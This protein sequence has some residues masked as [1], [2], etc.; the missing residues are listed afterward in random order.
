MRFYVFMQPAK[1]LDVMLS[2]IILRN[3]MLSRVDV[4]ADNNKL[5]SHLSNACFFFRILCF[6]GTFA[7]K[8]NVV[9]LKYK[10]L[11]PKLAIPA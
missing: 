9:P 3:K 1:L 10:L 7:P 4:S 5:T 2:K 8:A 11:G 6:V